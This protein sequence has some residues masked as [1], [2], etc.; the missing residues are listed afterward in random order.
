MVGKRGFLRVAEAVLGVIIVIGF[1]IFIIKSNKNNLEEFGS[2][3][4]II[5]DE[6]AKNDSLREIVLNG[7]AKPELEEFV[8]ER[9]NNPALNFSLMICELDSACAINASY[10][11][12][13][14]FYAAERAVSTN[15]R[16]VE[17]NPKKLKIFI[18]RIL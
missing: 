3:G 11:A 18:W 5:L 10:P 16:S 1:L 6:I 4:K 2:E 13:T 7:T 8:K 15:L 14:E 17:F 9:I 12:N